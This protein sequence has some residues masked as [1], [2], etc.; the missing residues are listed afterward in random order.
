VKIVNY[1]KKTHD[2]LLQSFGVQ[3][4]K[5]VVLTNDVQDDGAIM[6][7]SHFNSNSGI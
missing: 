7:T 6:D 5:S 3:Q 1:L 4:I 2:F